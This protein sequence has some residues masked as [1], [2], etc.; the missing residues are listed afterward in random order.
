MPVSKALPEGAAPGLSTVTDVLRNGMSFYES[1]QVGVGKKWGC[2][3][4]RQ[5]V[6]LHL[7]S[8]LLQALS[9]AEV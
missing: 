3:V 8:A 2:G 1:L 4:E 5:A 9:G 6:L 7:C